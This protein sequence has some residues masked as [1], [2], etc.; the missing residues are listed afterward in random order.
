M[1][2][3]MKQLLT[4]ISAALI[5]TA[6]SDDSDPASSVGSEYNAMTNTLKDLRDGQTYKTVT[7]GSQTWMA[8]DL[9]FVMD[10]NLCD[11]ITVHMEPIMPHCN[12]YGWFYG[13]MEAVSVCP[14]GWHLP[15]KDEWNALFVAVGDTSIA[16]K[17]LKS[18]SGW[19]VD[20]FGQSGVGIDAFGFS[21]LPAGSLSND[22]ICNSMGY[23][24][25]F[26][27][28]TED[29]SGY[30][31]GVYLSVSFDNAVL[32]TVNKNNGLSVRCLKD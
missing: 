12:E 5:F 17:V 1:D 22:G 19:N 16:G 14:D 25:N 29:S 26:W 6:C 21:A 11:K 20:E 23:C 7:I 4:S 2:V 27:S 3:L 31:Y 9:N 32:R 24:A 13:W 10:S 28:S 18:A 8:E 15:S 30:A